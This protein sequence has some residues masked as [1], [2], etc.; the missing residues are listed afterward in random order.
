LQNKIRHLRRFFR[1]WAKN[2]SGKYK[3]EKERLLN[4]IDFLESQA[5]TCPPTE[6]GRMDLKNANDQLNKLRRE[7]EIK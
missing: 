7:E 6:R 1:G 3:K 2:I 4:L 5:E